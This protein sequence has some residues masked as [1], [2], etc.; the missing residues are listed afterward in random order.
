MVISHPLC[1]CRQMSTFMRKRRIYSRLPSCFHL[2]SISRAPTP[3]P[4]SALAP[5]PPP[6]PCPCI[7][8]SFKSPPPRPPARAHRPSPPRS[9]PGHCLPIHRPHGARHGARLGRDAGVAAASR[10]GLRPQAWTRGCARRRERWSASTA[11]DSTLGRRGPWPPARWRVVRARSRP[12]GSARAWDRA[13][14]GGPTAAAW[15]LA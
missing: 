5:A 1:H 9:P 15:E 4:T 7:V 10:T 2:S 12:H 3:T 11:A 13:A 14:A 8:G 6:R